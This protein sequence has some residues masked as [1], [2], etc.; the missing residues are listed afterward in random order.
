MVDFTDMPLMSALKSK[1]KWLNSNQRIISENIAHANTPGYRAKELEKPEFSGLVEKLTG[2][3]EGSLAGVEAELNEAMRLDDG[4][5]FSSRF[6]GSSNTYS[7]NEIQGNEENPNGNSVV[8]EEEMI[9]MSEN[10]MQFDL[11]SK[12]YKKNIGL[13]KAALGKGGR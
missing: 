2:D 7:I 12:L 3:I 8:L 13:L 5:S 11:A 4:G 6:T 1:M 9:K 10:Q